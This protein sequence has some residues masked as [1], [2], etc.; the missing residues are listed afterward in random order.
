MCNLKQLGSEIVLSFGR[1][2]KRM[3]KRARKRGVDDPDSHGTAQDCDTGSHR[4]RDRK[5][6][7]D[8]VRNVLHELSTVPISRSP[9]K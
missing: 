2:L 4:I 1:E 8:P 3:T 6:G 9:S 5:A 7:F